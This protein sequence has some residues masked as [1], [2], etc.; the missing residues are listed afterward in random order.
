MNEASAA[1]FR[2]C[3]SCF[4]ILVAFIFGCFSCAPQCIKST[5]FTIALGLNPNFLQPTMYS[6]LFVQLHW[7]WIQIFC[8]PQCTKSTFLQL[9]WAWIQIFCT[10]QRTQST[11]LQLHWAWIQNFP[12][13]PTYTMDRAILHLSLFVKTYQ[14]TITFYQ[15]TIKP[16]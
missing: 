2:W 1:S 7:A 12:P 16:R 3:V 11:F 4:L 5:F 10:P 15:T 8:N 9:H 6:L 14:T 13:R